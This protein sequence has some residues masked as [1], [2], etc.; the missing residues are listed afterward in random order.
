MH[1]SYSNQRRKQVDECA[2]YEFDRSNSGSEKLDVT[3]HPISNCLF[4]KYEDKCLKSDN[5]KA[6]IKTE[7][8]N[9]KRRELKFAKEMAL[10]TDTRRLKP[11]VCHSDEFFNSDGEMESMSESEISGGVLTVE[12]LDDVTI[13]SL[14]S[15][16]QTEKKVLLYNKKINKNIESVIS[17][18]DK[19]SKNQEKTN[20]INMGYEYDFKVVADDIK[21][22]LITYDKIISKTSVISATSE[23]RTG[24]LAKATQSNTSNKL[25]LYEDAPSINII[26]FSLQSVNK[27]KAILGYCLLLVNEKNN[28]K[29][30]INKLR[31]SYN[32]IQ[33]DNIKLSHAIRILEKS[34][35]IKEHQYIGEI[36]NLK[37]SNKSNN[38]KLT[39]EINL[40]M[41]IRDN[42]LPA[43]NQSL[44]L[45]KVSKVVNLMIA[46][47]FSI[48]EGEIGQNNDICSEE[49]QV[50]L[51]KEYILNGPLS[52]VD[53]AYELCLVRNG[54]YKD[55]QNYC[56][57]IMKITQ[58]YNGLHDR[59][60]NEYIERLLEKQ[61]DH[62]M[63]IKMMVM[64]HKEYIDKMNEYFIKEKENIYE[65]HDKQINELMQENKRKIEMLKSDHLLELSL[66]Q[67]KY[68]QVMSDN[69]KEKDHSIK[70]MKLKFEHVL[71]DVENN[72][73]RE[74]LSTQLKYEE[75]ITELKEHYKNIIDQLQLEMKRKELMF[76]DEKK[77]LLDEFII[78][79]KKE[80]DTLREEAKNQCI[81]INDSKNLNILSGYQDYPKKNGKSPQEYS[82]QFNDIVK[83]ID[84]LA[85]RSSTSQLSTSLPSNNIGSSNPFLGNN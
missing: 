28:E 76:E 11:E 33:Q 43:R 30:Y 27:L 25:L 73:D 42:D 41:V 6:I 48:S 26:K 51:D 77:M 81:S 10:T 60:R 12:N 50:N 69:I 61:K 32:V 13:P 4:N 29:K 39:N 44:K 80:V 31:K 68:K 36:K 79:H 55:A 9:M 52:T 20:I 45:N 62:E 56:E 2:E 7:L 5:A 8:A 3:P 59:T 70:A 15:N 82:D 54:R 21:K 85:Y 63:E 75:Q 65:A 64:S 40:E 38:E 23:I 72:K 35:A 47:K 74:L 34:R 46:E 19:I 16:L 14:E 24:G 71:I 18:L 84:T 1:I 53:S 37:G 67:Q 57:G 17:I 66:M 22:W 58:E 49:F 78:T 83:R